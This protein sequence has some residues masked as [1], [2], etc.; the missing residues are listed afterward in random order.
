MKRYLFL[1]F[2]SFLLVSMVGCNPTIPSIISISPASGTRGQTLDVTIY[3]TNFLGTTSVYFS[4]TNI[5]VNSF[6]VISSTEIQ[7]NIHIYQT[8]QLGPNDVSVTSPY[9]TGEGEKL[10][11]VAGMPSI[12]SLAPATGSQG[13]I[14]DVT[15]LGEGFY[16]VTSVSFGSGITVDPGYQVI[17]VYVPVMIMATISISSTA[18]PGTRNVTVATTHGT[19]TGSG[20]FTVTAVTVPGPVVSS[21]TPSYGLR[22]QTLTVS[23]KGSNFTG[24]PTDV[25]FGAGITTNSFTKISLFEIQANISISS[26]AVLGWRDV[27]VTIGGVTGVGID[28]F[29]VTAFI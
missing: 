2:L 27:S 28:L 3:G 10:F 17:S 25:S 7:A 8:A 23:I 11:T 19:A 4:G 29:D 13:S 14:M 24:T 9:G 20:L 5:W 12:T 26:E 15:I 22:D 16:G 21:V 1:V 18:T 6:E